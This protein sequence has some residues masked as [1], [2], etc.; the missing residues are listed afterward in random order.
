MMWPREAGEGRQ[1]E[2]AQDSA[3]AGGHEQ[4][5]ETRRADMKNVLR[6][7]GHELGI[8]LGAKCHDSQD[9]E[10]GKKKGCLP[11]YGETLERVPRYAFVL[12]PWARRNGDHKDADDSDEASQGIN[13]ETTTG[14]YQRDER[15]AEGWTK[16]RGAIENH[17]IEGNG[18]GQL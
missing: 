12:G 1:R 6:E 15:A 14:A 2:T 11:R 10:K 9:R 17:L 18:V 4:Q 3:G 13:K 7:D 8:G 16:E 5:T